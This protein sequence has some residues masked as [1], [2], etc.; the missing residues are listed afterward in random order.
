[1]DLG[2]GA[3][4]SAAGMSFAD[5][6]QVGLLSLC[7]QLEQPIAL[8]HSCPPPALPVGPGWKETPW[9]MATGSSLVTQVAP[10]R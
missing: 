10:R 5:L 9:H 2:R 3:R 1:M 8:D 4:P 6:E 7:Q